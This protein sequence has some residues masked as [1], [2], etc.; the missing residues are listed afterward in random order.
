MEP[1]VELSTASWFSEIEP[2][3]IDAYFTPK[4]RFLKN[5]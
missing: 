1:C 2:P 3:K 5:T 4:Q